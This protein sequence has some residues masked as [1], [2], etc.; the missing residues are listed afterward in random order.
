ML[1]RSFKSKIS[2]T[3]VSISG[4]VIWENEEIYILHALE[5]EVKHQWVECE[6]K[7][8]YDIVRKTGYGVEIP[9]IG[10][11][12]LLSL[13]KK[14]MNEISNEIIVGRLADLN[15]HHNGKT[16]TNDEIQNLETYL[17]LDSGNSGISVEIFGVSPDCSTL[18]I[19]PNKDYLLWE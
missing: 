11:Y 18:P 1:T 16:G 19:D 10:Q 2:G 13:D 7:D 5:E 15:L 17:E 3:S 8:M 12:C 9:T 4:R 6:I 14:H